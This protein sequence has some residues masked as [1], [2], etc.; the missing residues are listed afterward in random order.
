MQAIAQQSRLKVDPRD[1]AAYHA[2][3]PWLQ[4]TW[5]WILLVGPLVAPVFMATGLSIL[6]P[7]ADGIY[8]IGDLVCPKVDFHFMF[9]GYP[10]AVCASCW[11]AVFGLWTVRLLYGR[12]GEGFGIFS[13]FKLAPFWTQWQQNSPSLKL[14][15]LFLGFIP[16]SLDV[17]LTDTGAWYSPQIFMMFVGYLGGLAAALLMLPAGAEMRE[18][19]ERKQLV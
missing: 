2:P 6:R 4:D 13:R 14:S 17:M 16:W 12:A 15:V 7:F 11:A 1:V 19:V 9:V 18:R 5:L 3:R 10:V 8:L